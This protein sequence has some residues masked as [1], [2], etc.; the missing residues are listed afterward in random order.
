M[1]EEHLEELRKHYPS[2]IPLNGKTPIEKGWPQ[3]CEEERPYNAKDFRNRNAGIPCGT[4]N[5]IIVIDIDDLGLFKQFREQKGY[6]LPTTRVHRTGNGGNHYVYRYPDN[7]EKYGCKAFK[8][9]GFDIRGDGG[10]VVAPYSIHPET[11]KPYE[12]MVE[13]DIA[14]APQWLL[15]L[16][17][18][19]E[20]PKTQLIARDPSSI[21]NGNLDSLDLSYPVK[22]LI[23][24][25]EEMGKRS[26]AIFS[27]INALKR[28]GCSDDQIISIFEAHRTG[29]GDKYFEKGSPESR[30]KWLQGEIRRAIEKRAEDIQWVTDDIGETISTHFIT[31][32]TYMDFEQIPPDVIGKGFLLHQGHTIISGQSGV[33]KSLLRTEIALHLAMGIDWLCFPIKESKRVVI[34]QYENSIP[35]EYRRIIRMNKSLNFGPFHNAIKFVHPSKRFDLRLDK[36]RGKL[37]ERVKSSEGEV[38]IYDCLSNLHSVNENDNME[39]RAV[40]ETLSHINA[41]LGTAC[42]VMHH[43]GKPAEG[44]AEQYKARGASSIIDWAATAANF[45]RKAHEHKTHRILELVKVRDAPLP[46]PLLL[47]RGDDLLLR[48][49]EEDTLCPPGRVKEILVSNFGGRV[50]MQK[51]L[52]DAIQKETGCSPRTAKEGVKK[53]VEMKQINE[54]SNGRYKGYSV[55]IATNAVA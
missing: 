10:Q 53:A 36:D 16:A 46:T 31:M 22:K 17:I 5:R 13:N 15:N 30:Q 19:E 55:Q 38:I 43:F 50:D 3:Y 14:P 8:Q 47:E 33:G 11:G 4:A 25:G 12:V 27:V 28:A 6:E 45:K 7:G 39:V 32:S 37:L 44:Q 41:T 20:P 26:E 34:F 42:L 54:F 48:I 1:D 49:G 23:K 2:L 40:L 29:I 9:H 18:Q 24:D 52:L 21:R 35:M 51:E